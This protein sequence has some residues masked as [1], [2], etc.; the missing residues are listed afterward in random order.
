MNIPM[1]IIIGTFY[2]VVN[3]FANTSSVHH[4]LYVRS[5][6]MLNQVK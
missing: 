4:G 3:I 1:I 5:T 6:L 2:N